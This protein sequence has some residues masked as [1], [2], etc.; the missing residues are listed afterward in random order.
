MLRTCDTRTVPG[1][2]DLR[3]TPVT[4]ITG[5]ST[6]LEEHDGKVL[7]IVNVASR[8]GN[9]P[10]YEALEVLQ[11]RYQERGFTVLGF[12]C[13]QFLGQEP[14]SNEKIMDYCTT[15][16]GVTFPMYAKVKVNGPRAHPL[17]ARLRAVP[18]A[19]GS[20]GRVEWNFE[21]FLVTPDD[22]VHRFR[23]GVLP[24]DPAIVDLIERS[25]PT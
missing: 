25:L 9:T 5:E 24:E 19:A 15:T 3:S 20:A 8:C 17:Y 18:D 23:P 21:K 4:T 16:W 10:Q 7:L 11:R 6:T 14:G 13:N 2:Q 22:E 12:P 1:M